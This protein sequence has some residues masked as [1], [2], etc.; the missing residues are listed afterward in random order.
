MKTNKKKHSI[1]IIEDSDVH[2]ASLARILTPYYE[3]LISRSGHDGIE[4]ARYSKPDVI[5]LDII[6]P[7]MDGFETITILKKN[8]STRYIPVIFITSLTKVEDE[9]KGLRLGGSDYI[10][11]PFSDEI[12]KL[13]IQNQIR[14]L[15]YI[16]SIEQLSRIDQLTG[17]P[18]R[19]SFHE[20]LLSEW[21]LAV[22]ERTTI[23]LLVIDIDHFKKCND[24]F[25]HLMGDVV[26]QKISKEIKNNLQKPTD[27]A[28]RWGGEEFIAVLPKTESDGALYVAEKIRSAIESLVVVFNDGRST[29]VTTSVGVATYS[30]TKTCSINDFIQKA[31]N[32]LY[33]AKRNGRNNVTVHKD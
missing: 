5:I 11:K 14:M 29:N 27:L 21:K 23:S 18:N 13:R 26:L 30:P 12:V 4:L 20:R 22:R 28:A 7:D 24:T 8:V 1:L 10:T 6:M 31:D 9:E 15:E 33:E 25:G 2:I 32:A 16:H 19:R 17:L 3:V